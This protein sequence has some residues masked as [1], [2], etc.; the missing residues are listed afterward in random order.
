MV[1]DVL[2]GPESSAPQS[3]TNIGN[4]LFFSASGPEGTELWRSTGTAS[5]TTLVKDINLAL[6]V[7]ISEAFVPLA[8]HSTLVRTMAQ[9]GSSSGRA[10][11]AQRERFW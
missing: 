7:A 8:R 4:L 5:G 1:K 10:M 2:P 3:L 9:A 11:V 6:T